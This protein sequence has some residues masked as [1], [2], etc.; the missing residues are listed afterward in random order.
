V[1][2]IAKQIVTHKNYMVKY[3]SPTDMGISCAWFAIT[4]DSSVSIAALREIER[5][6]NRY[7]EMIDRWEGKEERTEKCDELY[8]KAK[9]YCED[10][11]Y[12]LEIKL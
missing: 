2:T 1:M 8:E 4:D 12:D 5:R 9:K 10:K 11:K 7:Q 6:K 3:Q